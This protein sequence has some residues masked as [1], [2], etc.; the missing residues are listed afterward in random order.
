MPALCHRSYSFRNLLIDRSS[1]LN[2]GSFLLPH[3]DNTE[4]V[5]A[6]RAVDDFDILFALSITLSSGFLFWLRL[7]EAQFIFRKSPSHQV[8]RVELICQHVEVES[9]GDIFVEADAKFLDFLFV[10]QPVGDVYLD[11]R[12]FTFDALQRLD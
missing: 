1:M 9:A 10:E 6:F 11:L 12:L 3:L 8:A 5:L 4:F 7:A 2:A